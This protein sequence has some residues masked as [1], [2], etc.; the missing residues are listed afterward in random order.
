MQTK[1]YETSSFILLA[2]T[3]S[4]STM[5]RPEQCAN[6]LKLKIKTPK[7]FSSDFTQCSGVFT[8]DFEQRDCSWVGNTELQYLQNVVICYVA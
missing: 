4:K 5:E 2:F 7:Q 1:N 3:C 8:V 6:C